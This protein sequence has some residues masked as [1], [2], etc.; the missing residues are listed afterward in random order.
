MQ[1]GGVWSAI[2]K[3]INLT[4]KPNFPV[5]KPTLLVH[6]ILLHIL[7]ATTLRHLKPPLYEQK[8]ELEFNRVLSFVLKDF[9]IGFELKKKGQI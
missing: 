9:L 8:I 6:L 1:Q 7:D 3:D 5:H 4:F 2:Y